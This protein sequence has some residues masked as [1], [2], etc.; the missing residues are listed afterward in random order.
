MCEILVLHH[1]KIC[2]GHNNTKMTQINKK[3]ECLGN[4][5]KITN[6]LREKKQGAV[7]HSGKLHL[8][9]SEFQQIFSLSILSP[10][11]K[12]FQSYVVF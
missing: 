11:I 7:G 10:P 9:I 3:S 5:I 6:F 1:S 2:L 12:K 8:N 4:L